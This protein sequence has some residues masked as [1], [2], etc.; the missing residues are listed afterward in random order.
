MA[1]SKSNVPSNETPEARFKRMATMRVNKAL[2][3]VS[4]LATLSGS[5]YRSSPDQIA[6]IEA[7]FRD[8][9]TETFGRLR[10]QKDGKQ[11]FTL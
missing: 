6:K 11:T 9:L 2:K 3:A 1:K 10:G 5:R 4:L 7:A 8:V